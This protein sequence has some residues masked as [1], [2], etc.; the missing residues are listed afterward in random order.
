[1][2][3]AILL[4]LGGSLH[5]ILMCGPL[6]IAFLNNR[7]LFLERIYLNLGRVITYVLLGALIGLV[8]KLI[9]LF[10]I[11]QSVS[12]VSGILIL[13]VYFVPKLI[14]KEIQIAPVNKL[15][16]QNI[17]K[18]LNHKSK[19]PFSYLLLGMLN[20]LLPCGLVYTALIASVAQIGL[21]NS[22]RFMALF[23]LSTIPAMFLFALLGKGLLEKVKQK[24]IMGYL[25]NIIVLIVGVLFILRGL[26]LGIPFISPQDL[27]LLDSSK[28]VLCH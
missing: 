15:V 3:A 18:I 8:G 23:G 5:C 27:E 12:I 13:L 10:Q 22:M 7:K 6:H 2:L 19:S 28:E 24:R 14:G 21:G 25:L 16:S 26:N 11:Q 9:P 20:G 17:S 4:G 1:M